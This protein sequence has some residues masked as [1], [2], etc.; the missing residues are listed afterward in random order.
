MRPDHQ[1]FCSML[2]GKIDDSLG[3]RS[4][5]HEGFHFNAV[6][7]KTIDDLLEFLLLLAQLICPLIPPRIGIRCVAYEIGLG[8]DNVQHVERSSNHSRQPSGTPNYH[9]G[10]LRKINCCD[11]SFHN[12]SIVY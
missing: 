12:I 2:I 11:D 3:S 4:L 8:R 5:L 6:V 10:L 9:A 7:L 1:Q